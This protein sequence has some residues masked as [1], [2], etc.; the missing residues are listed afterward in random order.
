MKTSLIAISIISA[1]SVT[2]VPFNTFAAQHDHDH[3]TVNYVGKDAS[4]HTAD[5]NRAF[6]T[7]L[8][9][10]DTA[11]F[12]QSSKHLIAK[13]DDKA[14]AILRAE[15]EF[16]I[17]KAPDTVNPSLHRQAKLN[18]VADGL[19]KVRDGIYQ[20]R[21]T[22]LSNLTLIRSENGW[23]AYDV[24]LTKEAAKISSAPSLL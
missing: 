21:G 12:E 14:A 4:V 16:I 10:T 13:L 3:L 8:N 6:A 20:V 19:Y 18:M 23:I 11:A 5:A 1:L 17:D 9:F 7:H 2:M 15:F 22:D 24:L